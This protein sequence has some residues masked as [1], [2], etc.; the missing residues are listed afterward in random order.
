MT[1]TLPANVS[2]PAA[3]RPVRRSV[4]R[5]GVCPPKINPGWRRWLWLGWALGLPL[6]AS[7][8]GDQHTGEPLWQ[9]AMA[10]IKSSQALT[11]ARVVT[12]VTVFDG[13]EALLGTI[14]SVETVSWT[15]GHPVWQNVAKKSTGKPGFTMELNLNI[16]KDPG[17]LLDGYGEWRPLAAAQLEG[18][19]YSVW[20]SHR[21]GDETDTARVFVDPQTS[22]PKRADFTMPIHSNLGTRLVALTVLFGPGPKQ[23]WVPVQA[24]IDQT[25]RFM[26]WKRHLVITKTFHGWMEQPAS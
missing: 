22:R 13:D 9:A 26:F 2:R 17:G 15:S 14:E 25:G 24:T 7:A 12:V 11:A 16:E 23:T 6:A 20:E 21:P 4:P 18:A 19:S 1:H 3:L 8:S 5:A 10:G